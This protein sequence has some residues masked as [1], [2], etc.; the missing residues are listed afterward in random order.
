MEM[1]PAEVVAGV[2]ES[3]ALSILRWRCHVAEGRPDR[4]KK[5]LSILRW[6][7]KAPPLLEKKKM[8][9]FFQ[10]SVGD[11]TAHLRTTK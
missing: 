6:R 10:Y 4:R 3:V 8:K 11:A 2:S 7:C 9:F 5:S 1:Q